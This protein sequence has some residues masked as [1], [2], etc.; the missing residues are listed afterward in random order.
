MNFSKANLQYHVHCKPILGYW[1]GPKVGTQKENTEHG[2]KVR[3]IY[4]QKLQ[5]IVSNIGS[6]N[7][8][9]LVLLLLLLPVLGYYYASNI[10]L[11]ESMKEVSFGL[12]TVVYINTIVCYWYVDKV[13]NIN[14]IKH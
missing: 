9:T 10:V 7:F 6:R 1:G 5:R 3:K 13:N 2:L 4:E 12:T 8:S 14:N 11:E